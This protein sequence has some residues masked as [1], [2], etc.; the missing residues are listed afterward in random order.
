MAGAT[1]NCCH[2]GTSSV[3]TIQPRTSLQRYF[4]QS[5][6]GRVHAC[7]AVT[8]HLHF[9][10]NDWDLLRAT[11]VTREWNRYRNE[12]Q[13][14]KLTL[15]KKILLQ[16]LWGPKP[17]TFRSQV[18]CSVVII[19]SLFRLLSPAETLGLKQIVC[20]NLMKNPASGLLSAIAVFMTLS[21][22]LL[23]SLRSEWR[24]R[25]IR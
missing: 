5:H 8:C 15:E 20:V 9:W 1:L 11:A 17:G 2:L 19:G 4:T 14:R 12:S 6:V 23:T 22:P 13:H 21:T 18:R 16:L 10:Q 7:L 3:Y 25:S 24:C